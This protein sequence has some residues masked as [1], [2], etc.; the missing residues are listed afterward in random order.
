M[1]SAERAPSPSPGAAG[2]WPLR[3]AAPAQTGSVRL[4]SPPGT[5]RGAL[6]PDRGFLG[7]RTVPSPKHGVGGSGRLGSRE[8]EAG[9]APAPPHSVGRL[10]AP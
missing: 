9:G 5:P 3:L 7:A 8:P 1:F 10:G 4:S 2:R 6:D